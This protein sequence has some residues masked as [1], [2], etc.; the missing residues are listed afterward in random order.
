MKAIRLTG[1]LVGV[2][3]LTAM[4]TTATVTF[5]P[6]GY[7]ADY[8]NTVFYDLNAI[9]GTG[10]RWLNWTQSLRV[11]GDN[12]GLCSYVLDMGIRDLTSGTWAPYIFN[13]DG[14][15]GSRSWIPAYKSIKTNGGTVKDPGDWGGPGLN[16]MAT[17]G[18]GNSNVAYI[19]QF[20]AAMLGYSPYVKTK[21]GYAGDQTWGVGLDS[22][23]SVLLIDP[24]G[25]YDLAQGYIDLTG[26]APGTYR[27]EL[28][29]V[30]AWVIQ[31]GLD[32]NSAV[33]NVVYEVPS[34]NLA[35]GAF[36]FT[37][38]PEPATLVLLAGAAMLVRRRRA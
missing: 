22:R 27:L 23:K 21:N 20:G 2:L 3:A 26:W 24:Q 25:T 28:I 10:D 19:A 30:H 13:Y 31:A 17:L 12:Q 4:A 7:A 9:P 5:T 8:D 6:R 1:L 37:I 33:D 36:E 14:S 35:G 32:L 15:D 29:A 34:A 11:Q 18:S 16:A 38:V